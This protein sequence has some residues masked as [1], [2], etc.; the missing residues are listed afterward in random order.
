MN[1]GPPLNLTQL[2][3]EVVVPRRWR[4]GPPA[5]GRKL[6]RQDAGRVMAHALEAP[7]SRE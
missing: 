4:V 1:L 3:P 7:G 5:G 6:G 2:A